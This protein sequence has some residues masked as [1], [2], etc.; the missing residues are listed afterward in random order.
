MILSTIALAGALHA[1]PQPPPITEPRAAH[2]AAHARPPSRPHGQ[3]V[4]ARTASVFA[5]ACHYNSELVTAGGEAL[6]A[7]SFEGGEHAGVPL[8]GARLALALSGPKNLALPQ[9]ERHSVVYLPAG[10]SAELRAA[11]LDWLRSEH[12]ALLGE[13]LA[14]RTAELGFELEGERFALRVGSEAV[15]SGSALPNRECCKMPYEVWYRPFEPSARTLV[16]QV[17]RFE[18]DERL[19]GTRW[20]RSGENS[21]F[22]GRF[23]P[24]RLGAL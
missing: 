21:A 8:A 15:L 19:L 12:G 24:Q 23:G 14:A 13:L 2:V 9:S 18:C 3:Y 7:W 20:R 5:G 6:L 22:F 11:L 17:E 16:G 4:E 10:A 1:A